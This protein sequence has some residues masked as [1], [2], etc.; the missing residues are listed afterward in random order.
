M[1]GHFSAITCMTAV[2]S[3]MITGVFIGDAFAEKEISSST[4][5]Q[6]ENL[7]FKYKELGEVEFK[8]KYSH[9]NFLNDCIK[10][11]KDKN[12]HF[13]G[14]SK[15]DNQFDKLKKTTQPTS[16]QIKISTK[17]ISTL[18]IG[19]EKFNVKF[20]SCNKGESS[21]PNFIMTS[22]K[23]KFVGTASKISIKDTCDTY[24]VVLFA[25][26]PSTI[27]ITPIAESPTSL[28]LPIKRI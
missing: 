20:S 11:Y 12:W 15:I 1:K 3:L 27:S 2:F 25:K 21:K 18:K 13:T 22:D 23:E 26:K 5:K 4:K 8:K 6:C 16:T 17:I 19:E 24:W 28:G 7:Y 9:K 14:K 10:L